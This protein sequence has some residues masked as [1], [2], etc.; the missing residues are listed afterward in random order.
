MNICIGEFSSCACIQN[1]RA[2]TVIEFQSDGWQIDMSLTLPRRWLSFWVF[3]VFSSLSF[4]DTFCSILRMD[5]L[6]VRVCESGLER[7][8]SGTKSPNR[9]RWLTFAQI[10]KL[11]CSL[12]ERLPVQWKENTLSLKGHFC[13]TEINAVKMYKIS[14]RPQLS[15]FLAEAPTP[16]LQV[17]RVVVVVVVLD[18]KF[19]FVNF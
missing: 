14:D 9:P 12:S 17:M 16:A 3:H 8:K 4:V 7:G 5:G 13:R 2:G 6:R 18:T 11:S 10:A 1:E 15:L 19:N